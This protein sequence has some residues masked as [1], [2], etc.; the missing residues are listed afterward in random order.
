MKQRVLLLACS[1]LFLFASMAWAV[2]FEEST[3]L[4]GELTFEESALLVAGELR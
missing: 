3:V 1:M 2:D 4:S